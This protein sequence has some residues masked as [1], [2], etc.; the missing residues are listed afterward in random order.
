MKFNALNLDTVQRLK[1]LGYKYLAIDDGRVV[2]YAVREHVQKKDQ[3][4]PFIREFNL[5]LL[6]EDAELRGF[7][8][9]QTLVQE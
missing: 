2:L 9:Y 8:Q 1:G 5:D 6:E 4:S 7:L 3:I